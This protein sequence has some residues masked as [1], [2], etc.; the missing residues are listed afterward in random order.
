MY[1]IISNSIHNSIT[2]HSY[3]SSYGLWRQIVLEL[4]PHNA[5]VPMGTHD[6]SPDDPVLAWL[7]ISTLLR[8]AVCTIHICNSLPKVEW[9][10]FF[11]SHPIQL[12]E[13]G[14][15]SLVAKASFVAHKYPLSI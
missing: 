2:Y 12:Q 13:G 4:C 9:S 14:V 5:T 1:K 11:V 6:S 10:V 7:L 3:S 15:C 8:L